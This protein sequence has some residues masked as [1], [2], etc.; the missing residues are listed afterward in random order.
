M[1]S[2]DLFFKND[3][4]LQKL[5]IYVFCA[6]VCRKNYETLKVCFRRTHKYAIVLS[7]ANLDQIQWV[8]WIGNDFHAIIAT[9]RATGFALIVG[10]CNQAIEVRFRH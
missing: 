6:S 3:F 8:S 10:C 9:M 4:A 2:E 7:Y 5:Q 1:T